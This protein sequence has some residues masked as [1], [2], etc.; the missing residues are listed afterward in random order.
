LQ[1]RL[2]GVSSYFKGAPGE[3]R[4]GVPQYARAET[5]DVYPGIDVI[6]HDDAGL[7]PGVNYADHAHAFTDEDRSASAQ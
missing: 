5:K 7:C 4:V 2:P 6:W 3:W 1:D